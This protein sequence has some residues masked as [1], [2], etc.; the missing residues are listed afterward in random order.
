VVL[1]EIHGCVAKAEN[2]AVAFDLIDIVNKAA[3]VILKCRNV[4][5]APTGLS[6]EQLDELARAFN[7]GE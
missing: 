1:W 2:P 7:L 3:S 6:K 4:G 5:H